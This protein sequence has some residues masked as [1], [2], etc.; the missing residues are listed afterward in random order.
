[1]WRLIHCIVS[2]YK[3]ISLQTYICTWY[4]GHGITMY[5][6]VLFRHTWHDGIMMYYYVPGTRTNSAR[7]VSCAFSHGS[8]F[9][10]EI[11]IASPA[12][13]RSL[14]RNVSGPLSWHV[15]LMLPVSSPNT[16]GEG[17]RQKGH[18]LDL[19]YN[20]QAPC[21]SSPPA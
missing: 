5:S 16:V 3:Y 7:R 11:Y 4:V 10:G 6:G 9:V 19:R 1:M 17:S 15:S 21:A 12:T 8:Q 14:R 13:V 20:M 18:K 2:F